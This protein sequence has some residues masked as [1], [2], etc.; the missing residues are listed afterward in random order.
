MKRL[1]IAAMAV[2]ALVSCS[3]APKLTDK[4]LIAGSFWDSIAIVNKETKAIEWAYAL[5]AGAEC[6][7]VSLTKDG[8]ILISYKKGARVIDRAGKT[9]WDYTNVADTAELQTAYQNPDGTFFLA[10]CDNPMRIIE[11][12]SNGKET[13][14]IQYNIDVPIPHAQFRLV[15][16]S[17][18]G[19][20]L[21]PMIME[22]TVREVNSNG[23]LIKT[24]E[25]GGNPFAIDQLAN[26]NLLV[27]CGD[28]HYLVEID[29]A[30]GSVVNK[31]A[32]NDIKGVELQFVAQAKRLP[33]GNTMVSN[34][35]GHIQGRYP[36][37]QLIEYDPTGNLVW[38]FD[39]KDQVKYIS[40]FYPFSE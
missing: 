1:I 8:N 35:L 12:D 38:S 26:G 2:V 16:K 29:R 13:N 6:N 30:S 18:E 4:V 7:S 3:T 22:G 14:E 24:Y 37:P 28:G 25:V 40:G 32:Q 11:L 31:V 15:T 5:P 21:I 17:A 36:Q 33:N 27:A 23:E 34:W 10:V 39:N 20:Y 9:I 19:T